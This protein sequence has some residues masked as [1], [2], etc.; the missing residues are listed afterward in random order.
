[1]ALNIDQNKATNRLLF[2]EFRS[3]LCGQKDCVSRSKLWALCE[4]LNHG[5]VCMKERERERTSGIEWFQNPFHLMRFYLYELTFP[6]PFFMV[7]T[8]TPYFF[9]CTSSTQR[10]WECGDLW[11]ALC[12]SWFSHL[13]NGDCSCV[14][15]F[16]SPAVCVCLSYTKCKTVCSLS[17]CTVSSW[18]WNQCQFRVFSCSCHHLSTIYCCVVNIAHDIVGSLGDATANTLHF[19]FLYNLLLLRSLAVYNTVLLH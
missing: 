9:F 14:R 6:F 16:F 10:F 11:V 1:M 5:R 8:K 7:W 3:L 2:F 18:C 15:F 17:V 12:L 19:P 13:W 4:R